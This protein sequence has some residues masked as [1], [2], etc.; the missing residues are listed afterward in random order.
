MTGS[1]G[2]GAREPERRPRGVR[3]PGPAT[4][5]KL[6]SAPRAAGALLPVLPLAGTLGV[7]CR[8]VWGGR[9]AHAR[10]GERECCERWSELR[11]RVHH[12]GPEGQWPES[13]PSWRCRDSQGSWRLMDQITE[14][15]LGALGLPRLQWDRNFAAVWWQGKKLPPFCFT[16][17]ILRPGHLTSCL[18]TPR[19][20]QIPECKGHALL[21]T[22]PN[23]RPQRFQ[24]GTP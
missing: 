4:P 18:V 14:G 21:T 7:L 9:P 20:C 17:R 22:L 1:L 16:A 11:G 15:R 24:R 3:A 13:A 19:N 2:S 10:V 8:R 5:L 23:P 12:R 6:T